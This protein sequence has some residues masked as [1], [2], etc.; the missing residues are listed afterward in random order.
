MA[1]AIAYPWLTEPAATAERR[2]GVPA[3]AAGETPVAA[4]TDAPPAAIGAG[5][6]VAPVPRVCL[7]RS[8]AAR[9]LGLGLSTLKRMEQTGDAPPY[10]D[11]PGGRRL[12]PI[13]GL[14][15]WA[16]KRASGPAAGFSEKTP[17]GS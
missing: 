7:S 8:E 6:V 9:A 13:R 2:G 15:E 1:A 12:Y 10:F 14:V 3:I 16:D 4:A 11:A 17:A 5:D